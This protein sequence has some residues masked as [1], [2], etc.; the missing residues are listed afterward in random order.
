MF[1]TNSFE[2]QQNLVNTMRFYVMTV[3]IIIFVGTSEIDI[4]NLHVGTSIIQPQM[5]NS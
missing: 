5:K 2:Y 1:I 4:H 3:N